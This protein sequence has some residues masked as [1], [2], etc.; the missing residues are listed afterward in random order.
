MILLWA[1]LK[2]KMRRKICKFIFYYQTIERT[3]S[4]FIQPIIKM[5]FRQLQLIFSIKE[6]AASKKFT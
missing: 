5:N 6:A 3:Q 2:N 4:V 1:N